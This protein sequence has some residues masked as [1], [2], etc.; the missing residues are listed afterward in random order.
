[1]LLIDITM[2]TFNNSVD[3][4]PNSISISVNSRLIFNQG[5]WVGWH[6]ANYQLTVAQVLIECQPSINCDVHW[7][8]IEVSIKGINQHLTIDVFSTHHPQNIIVT[9][10]QCILLQRHIQ[11]DRHDRKNITKKNNSLLSL[12]LKSLMQKYYTPLVSNY[13]SFLL[14]IRFK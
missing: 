6:W 10:L 8:P 4:W 14:F 2:D 1:M 5:I 3:I 13:V 11:H 12:L 7:E 9:L